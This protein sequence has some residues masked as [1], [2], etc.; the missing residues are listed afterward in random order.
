M[1]TLQNT[2]VRPAVDA[3][4]VMVDIRHM[5]KWYGEFQVLKDI[6]LS[7]GSG[8]KLS[9]AGPPDPANQH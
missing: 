5:N 3:A 9:F 8:E 1:V 6:N 4:T 7:V 2:P